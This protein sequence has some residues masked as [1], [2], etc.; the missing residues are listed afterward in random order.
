MNELYDNEFEQISTSV[1]QKLFAGTFV[2]FS[3]QTNLNKIWRSGSWGPLT[4][5]NSDSTAP[6]LM[7]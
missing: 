6:V 2:L 5:T 7:G 4:Y 1:R 3:R